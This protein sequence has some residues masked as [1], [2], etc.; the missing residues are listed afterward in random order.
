MSDSNPTDRQN[1]FDLPE[2]SKCCFQLRVIPDDQIECVDCSAVLS[3]LAVRLLNVDVAGG[4]SGAHVS[5]QPFLILTDNFNADDTCHKLITNCLFVPPHLNL[6]F[7]FQGGDGGA[8][9]AV[10]GEPSSA[11]DETG[12]GFARYWVAA[13]RIRDHQIIINPVDFDTPF[14]RA[15]ESPHLL[16]KRLEFG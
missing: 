11:G 15:E 12:D 14:S 13:A 9:C 1:T 10:D 6:S 8:V 3:G 4:E 2:P 16:R 7:G 5:K